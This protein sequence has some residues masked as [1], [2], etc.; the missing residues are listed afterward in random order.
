[1]RQLQCLLYNNPCYQSGKTITPTKIVVHSTGVNNP[2]LLRYVQPHDGQTTGMEEYQP[3]RKTYTRTEMLAILGQN[4]Y[5][6]SW[7]RENI[8]AC[9]NAF[10]G[11]LD[12][13]SIAVVQTLPWTMRPWGVGSGDKGS[14]NDCAIQFE[15]C[16]D[17]HSS[18][19]YCQETFDVAAELCA[20]LMR[21]YPT[22]TEIVSHH[23]AH[24]R[25]YGSG[26]ND[27]DN[28]WPMHGLDMDLFR[29]KVQALLAAGTQPPE[30]PQPP[31]EDAGQL[32]RVRKSWADKA[33]QT[34]AY[35]S[36]DNA[37]NACGAGYTVYDQDGNAVYSQP[38][39]QVD[40]AMS[41]DDRLAGSYTVKANGGLHLRAGAGT[42][43]ASL[44]VMPDGASV[45]CYGFYTGDWLLVVADSGKT[46]FAHRGYL[47][48]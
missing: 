47:V 27:P 26:H 6:N 16:E 38:E 15:I 10:V 44:E 2:W 1:M 8:S 33:S 14:Y 3:V 29:A 24:Q 36:L 12:D 43:K 40:P 9:V 48:R 28:W 17:D 7:N 35:K 21:A 32:Y 45:R 23:E 13:G 22:I 34:G 5:G 11:K 20:H 19:A 25:G 41:R 37:K 18:A 39:I 46:G 42:D 4:R 31:E 30:Q